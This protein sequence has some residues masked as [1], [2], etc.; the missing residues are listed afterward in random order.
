MVLILNLGVW[1]RFF[2][3][4]FVKEFVVVNGFVV[5]FTSG[6]LSGCSGNSFVY[7]GSLGSVGK[8]VCWPCGGLPVDAW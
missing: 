4:D 6:F 1:S 3:N 2:S 8:W 5:D 7:C